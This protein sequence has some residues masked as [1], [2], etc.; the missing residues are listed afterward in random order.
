MPPHKSS[1][2]AE[3]KLKYYTL[4]ICLI[5]SCCLYS[6]KTQED[7]RNVSND[8][9]NPLTKILI[10]N[11]NRDIKN[12]DPNSSVLVLIPSGTNITDSLINNENFDL[13]K[14]NI[15]LILNRETE[16][17]TE[18][19]DDISETTSSHEDE[20]QEGETINAR[21]SREVNSEQRIARRF[22][23]LRGLWN[24]SRSGPLYLVNGTVCRFVNATPICTTLST[25][26]LIRK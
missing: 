22:S 26:G 10:S 8:C 17:Q 3:M 14:L 23:L 9:S 21:T 19:I 1:T 24:R 13:F 11:P 5:I 16:T 18:K 6:I 25:S 4:D 7:N 12:I 15:N 2:S 20:I